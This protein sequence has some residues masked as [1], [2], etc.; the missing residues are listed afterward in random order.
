M[1]C[2]PRRLTYVV[3]LFLLILLLNSV[4]ISEGIEEVIRSELLKTFGDSVRLESIR[5]YSDKKFSARDVAHVSI[6]VRRNV[7][8]GSA[9]LLLKDNKRVSVGLNLLWKHQVVIAMED[10][11][12]G[13]RLMPWKVKLSEVYMK[14][15]SPDFSIPMESVANYVALKPIQSGAIVRKSFLR[16][17]PI[18]QRGDEVRVTY[19]RGNI[20]ILVRAKAL[21]NGYVGKRIRLRLENGKVIQ[22]RVDSSGRVVID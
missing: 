7:S 14:Y 3:K 10:I 18:I 22:A 1:K 11:A 4:A 9:E 16:M 21:D 15:I 17:K 8:R 5:L 12:P 13:E 20:E 19:R 6:K 2:S